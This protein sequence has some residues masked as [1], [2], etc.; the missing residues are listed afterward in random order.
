MDTSDIG[1]L[2]AM[3]AIGRAD[4]SC[5]S[6]GEEIGESRSESACIESPGLQSEGLIS[7]FSTSRSRRSVQRTSAP[8]RD[9]GR[10]NRGEGELKGREIHGKIGI[11]VDVKAEGELPPFSLPP[12]CLCEAVRCMSRAGRG[13]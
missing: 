10:G 8:N 11:W 3:E 9:N 12:C 6:A 1:L 4:R 7:V 5:V 13:E 2:F